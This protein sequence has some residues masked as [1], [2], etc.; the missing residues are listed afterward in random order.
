MTT[1]CHVSGWKQRTDDEIRERLFQHGKQVGDCFEWTRCRNAGG[2]GWVTAGKRSSLVHRIAYELAYGPIPSGM[3][4]CH[5]CDNPACFRIDHLFL[6]TAADNSRDM[7][8]K[9][10]GAD[11]RGEKS[12]KAKL[13]DEQVAIIQLR[14]RSE[15][16]RDIATDFGIHPAHASRIVRGIRRAKPTTGNQVNSWQ[17]VDRHYSRKL[18]PDSVLSMRLIAAQ[19]FRMPVVASLFGVRAEQAAHIVYGDNWKNVP[20]ILNPPSKKERAQMM[21]Q[22]RK[23]PLASCRGY[24]AG[25]AGVAV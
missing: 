8:A 3:M 25:V 18:T 23:I 12:G 15:S 4:V 2:Y 11:T 1:K 20:G 13:T 5:K 21:L 17:H 14:A 16:L 6:G 7:A 10:R 22:G 24:A 19:G 9:G